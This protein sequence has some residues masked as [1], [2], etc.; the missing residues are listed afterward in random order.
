M[1]AD[2]DV[3]LVPSIDKTVL[4]AARVAFRPGVDVS[5][6]S[7]RRF[8]RQGFFTCLAK[9][10]FAYGRV[11]LRPQSY[12]QFRFHAH[13]IR[14]EEQLSCRRRHSFGPRH[15]RLGDGRHLARLAETRGRRRAEP[16]LDNLRPISVPSLGVIRDRPTT[17][18]HFFE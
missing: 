13:P 8:V 3:F 6:C 11:A 2:A 9:T 12:F 7:H 16:A 17:H 18:H 14:P 15:A 1:H 4:G 5:L 10:D